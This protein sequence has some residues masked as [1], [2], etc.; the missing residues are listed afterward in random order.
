MI[1]ITLDGGLIT[2][3]EELHKVF[4]ERLALPDYYGNNLDALYDVLSTYSETIEI[5][6]FNEEQL[7]SRVPFY[8]ERFLDVLKVAAQENDP[9]IIIKFGENRVEEEL[10]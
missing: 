7:C 3:R 9:R 8:K 4:R 6:I 5:T 10:W 2:D 1:A